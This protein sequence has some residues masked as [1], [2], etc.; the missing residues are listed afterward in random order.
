[1]PL[2]EVK[3]PAF[4]FFFINGV[5]TSLQL[6]FTK[7]CQK[8]MKLTPT[9]SNLLKIFNFVTF[10]SLFALLLPLYMGLFDRNWLVT[11]PP[12][13]PEFANKLFEQYFLPLVQY[14]NN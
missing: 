6:N 12:Q 9:Q 2:V 10:W 7:Y 1:M 11:N 5:L 13:I 8:T 4:S 14:N 3:C